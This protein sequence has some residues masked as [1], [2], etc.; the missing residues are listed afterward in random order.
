MCEKNVVIWKC[1]IL[2]ERIYIVD[3]VIKQ[4]SKLNTFGKSFQKI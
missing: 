1:S 4:K 3:R 2:K